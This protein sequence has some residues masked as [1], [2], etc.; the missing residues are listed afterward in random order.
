MKSKNKL[1][2]QDITFD[3]SKIISGSLNNEIRKLQELLLGNINQKTY[4]N[5]VK[6]IELLKSS[7]ISQNFLK[8]GEQAPNFKLS[9]PLGQK[10]ELKEVLK[11]GKVILSFI[12]GGW[13]PYCYIKLRA[14]EKKILEFKKNQAEIL[15]ISPERPD[16]CLNTIERNKLS[17]EILYDKA[18]KTAIDYKLIYKSDNNG[19][20]LCELGLNEA[21]TRGDI[22]YELPVPATFIIDEWMTIRYAFTNP[23]YRVGIDTDEL[24]YKLSQIN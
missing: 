2:C 23:D 20:L 17:Y 19:D 5:I 22:S 24:V 16:L 7:L 6:T 12:R 10:L 9:N 15:V 3:H 1:S 21:V 18:N 8:E 13:S 4:Q 11:K 14:F